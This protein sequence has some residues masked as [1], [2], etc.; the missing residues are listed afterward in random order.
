MD[1]AAL[2]AQQIELAARAVNTG[3]LEQVQRF[4]AL[5]MSSQ[6]FIRPG[7]KL[8]LGAPYICGGGRV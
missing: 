1:F 6:V 4:V 3:S 5:D 8:E 7:Q 2:R